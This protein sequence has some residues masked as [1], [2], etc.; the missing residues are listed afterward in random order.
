MGM[1]APFV[2]STPIGAPDGR[3]DILP[4]HYWTNKRFVVSAWQLSAE[5]IAVINHNA[6][7]I[8]CAVGTGSAFFPTFL[9]SS[10]TIRMLLADYGRT[11]PSQPLEVPA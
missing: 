8:F 3:E 4:A 1:P 11:I 5:E 10:E 2:G 9:G 7:K 6:G